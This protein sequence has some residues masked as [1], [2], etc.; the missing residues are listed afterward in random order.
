MGD[1][2]IR[3]AKGA[4]RWLG[5]WLDSALTLAENRRVRI[6]RARQAEARLRR[7]VSTYGVPPAA[8][9]SLQMAIIQGTMLCASELTWGGSRGV[10]GDYQAAINRMGRATLGAFR[11]TPLGIV[12]A[13]SGRIPARPLL[14]YRQARFAQRLHARPRGGEGPEEILDRGGTAITTR[15]RAAASLRVGPPWS[16]RSRASAESSRARSLWSVG[17]GP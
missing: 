17:R 2:E 5:I 8:A 3:F 13:E 6:G 1:Q 4:T 11:S 10:E 14:D 12:A 7:I 9:R 16:C 15:L